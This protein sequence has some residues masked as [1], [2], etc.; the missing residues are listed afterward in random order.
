MSTRLEGAVPFGRAEIL[1]HQMRGEAAELLRRS[2]GAG[3]HAEHA[4]R[5]L[6]LG[7]VDAL[8]ARMRVRRKHGHAVALAGQADVVDVAAS[9]EQKALVFD[10]PHCL[11]D[12][13]LGHASASGFRLRECGEC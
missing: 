11:P 2:I 6:G 10:A 1:R 5:G 13:E 8:D 9:A 7:D 3:E 4:G 12:A